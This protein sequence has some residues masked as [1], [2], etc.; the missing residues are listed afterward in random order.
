MDMHGSIADIIAEAIRIK[1]LYNVDPT[2][3]IYDAGPFARKF[4]ANEAGSVDFN[5]VNKLTGTA[6]FVGAGYGLVKFE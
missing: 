2:I 3:G 1:N 6:E 5:Y 4:K